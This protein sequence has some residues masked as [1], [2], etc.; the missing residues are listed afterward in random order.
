MTTKPSGLY[1]PRYE[2]DACGVAFVAR[3][4]GRPTHEVVQRGVTV[5]YETSSTA[6]PPA[7]T[8]P[9]ATAPGCSCRCPTRF[10]RGSVDFELPEPGRYG[11]AVCFLPRHRVQRAEL[12]AFIEAVVEAEG[13][14][15]P[16]LAR[17]AG[18]RARGAARARAP[19]RR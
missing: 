8:R 15:R 5:V 4:D 3:L 16:G 18:R 1:D 10:L 13:Q 14:T 19:W 7:P 12:K 6:A 2:H 9:P 17:R 11:V